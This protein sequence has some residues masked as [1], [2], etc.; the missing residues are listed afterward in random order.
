[1]TKKYSFTELLKKYTSI[2]EE[3]IDMFFNKFKIGNDLEFNIDEIDIAKYLNIKVKSLRK[4][5][6]NEFSI[7]E[8]YFEKVDYIKIRI[9]DRNKQKY[10]LNYRCME[11]LAMSGDSEESENIRIYL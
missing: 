10:M 7:N 3:F 2:D 8:N 11:K 9:N 6:K 5:L 4:R 1:M